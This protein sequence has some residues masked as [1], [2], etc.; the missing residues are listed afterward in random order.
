MAQHT[1]PPDGSRK[2][3]ARRT[4]R[5]RE[6][7]V[8]WINPG[9][10]VL[11]LRNAHSGAISQC[12]LSPLVSDLVSDSELIQQLAAAN[13]WTLEQARAWLREMALS[14][15]YTEHDVAQAQRHAH[16]HGSC[17]PDLMESGSHASN[18]RD[19]GQD[20]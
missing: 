19:R 1:A 10:R 18:S 13:Q 5:E 12:D 11:H 8:G 15:N 4:D 9:S 2:V 3:Y 16:P 6:E 20:A 14:A 17:G 7:F